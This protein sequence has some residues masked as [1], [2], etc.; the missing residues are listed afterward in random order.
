M[1]ASV[2]ARDD[3]VSLY[4]YRNGGFLRIGSLT[5]GQLP[6][7]IIAA[8]LT[9]TGWDDL[10]VSNAGDG[11][12]SVFFA[13]TLIGPINPHNTQIGV[14]AFLPPVTLPVG[15]G[16]S[17]VQ[18]VDTTG[19]SMLSLVVTNALTAQ[20]SVSY[21]LGN[22]TF[23]PRVP[24]RAGTGLS[25]IDSGSSPEVTSLDATAGV[26]SGAFTPGSPTDLVTINPGS[27]TMDV[28]PGLGGGRFANPVALNTES[29]A[30]VVRVSDLTSNGLGS[31]APAGSIPR[32]A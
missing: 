29:P 2:D 28:L 15:V 23:A 8:D 12:L 11:I 26:T 22:E 25:E 5:T 1:L 19:S 4:S 14:P 32:A 3:A 27:N 30:Q 18:T 21:N 13:K 16:V 20:V 17:D 9:G 10:V 31:L 7:Q 24:Y 6:A